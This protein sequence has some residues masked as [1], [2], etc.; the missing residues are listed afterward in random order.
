[1][2]MI[3]DFFARGAKLHTVRVL[4]EWYSASGH[5]EEMPGKTPTFIETA[6]QNNTAQHSTSYTYID[7][8]SRQSNSGKRAAKNP[9]YK[10]GDICNQRDFTGRRGART[11]VYGLFN[12]GRRNLAR[13]FAYFEWTG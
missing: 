4:E 1:M 9:V 8:S 12:R 2:H 3:G 10:N 11:L 6:Q 13:L 7:T 5:K